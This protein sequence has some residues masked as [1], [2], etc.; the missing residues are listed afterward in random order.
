MC[1]YNTDKSLMAMQAREV[2]VRLCALLLWAAAAPEGTR[3]PAAGC[4]ALQM[5]ALEAT[6]P[7]CTLPTMRLPD[8]ISC[9]A[10]KSSGQSIMP[11]ALMQ[12][13]QQIQALRGSIYTL[14]PGILQVGHRPP[15]ICELPTFESSCGRCV[16]GSISAWPPGT[17]LHRGRKIL[18]NTRLLQ[19]CAVTF[20]FGA[21]ATSSAQKCC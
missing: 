17:N 9:I 10:S 16:L 15:C 8:V 11:C 5:L 21:M 3:L 13:S 6:P 14:A 20:P 1:C 4:W 19:G 2:A 18:H 12:N 7:R